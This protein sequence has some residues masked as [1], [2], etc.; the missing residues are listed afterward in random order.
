MSRI[1]LHQTVRALRTGTLKDIFS[2]LLRGQRVKRSFDACGDHFRA[3]GVPLVTKQDACI[4]VGTRVYLWSDVKLSVVGASDHP[5]LLTIGDHVSLGTNT[6]IHCA[7]RVTIG[8]DSLIAWDVIIMDHDYHKLDG[9]FVKK[10]PV[11]LGERVWVGCRVIVTRGVTIGDGA[12]IAAGSVVTRDVPP[13]SLV[14]GNPA[15][16]IR[17]GVTWSP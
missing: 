12:V 11:I 15:R 10:A 8:S 7:D 6:Q 14:G 13:A 3:V 9:D 5:A 4:A 1:R 17:E 16:V 2:E